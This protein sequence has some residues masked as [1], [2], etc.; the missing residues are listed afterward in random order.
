MNLCQE[1]I[2]DLVVANTCSITQPVSTAGGL[3]IRT[4]EEV[5]KK[6]GIFSLKIARVCED[7]LRMLG[8]AKATLVSNELG[9]VVAVMLTWI[10]AWPWWKLDNDPTKEVSL[11]ANTD[12][13]VPEQ[14]ALATGTFFLTLAGQTWNSFIPLVKPLSWE[15]ISRKS[16][17]KLNL[18]FISFI[19]PCLEK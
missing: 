10:F 14:C 7:Y 19:L 4:H 17:L 3:S 18:D 16:C 5:T 2:V 11:P 1:V 15:P 8:L 12:T 9:A 6:R 13:F